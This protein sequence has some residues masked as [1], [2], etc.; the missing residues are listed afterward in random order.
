MSQHWRLVHLSFLQMVLSESPFGEN[1]LGQWKLEHTLSQHR[2]SLHSPLLH[3]L[4]SGWSIGI[5][6]SEHVK[7]SQ[8]T[9]SDVSIGIDGRSDEQKYLVT[10]VELRAPFLC[11]RL[12]MPIASD[13]FTKV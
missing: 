2:E 11:E 3:F 8:Y 1:L 4:R 9:V 6:P 5:Y 7:E 13:A 12:D 10:L